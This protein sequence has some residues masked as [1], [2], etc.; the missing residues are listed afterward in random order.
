MNVINKL[1]TVNYTVGRAGRPINLII[2]HTMQGFLTGTD[3][4]FNNPKAQVSAHEGVGLNGEVHLYVDPRNTAWGAGN[5]DYNRRAI[6]LETE[7]NRDPNGVVRTDAQYESLAQRVAL[8]CRQNA[9]P[10]D[11][12]H[13]IKHGEVPGTTHK[14]CPG[15]LDIDRVI[16]RAN[17][18]LTGAAPV[19]VS[20][21]TQPSFIPIPVSRLTVAAGTANVRT[22]PKVGGG[23]VVTSTL[24]KGQT[25]DIDGYLHTG[26]VINSGGYEGDLWVHS[27]MGHW[28]FGP[29]TTFDEA[30]FAP[31][32][33]APVAL[34]FNEQLASVRVTPEIGANLRTAPQ[35]DMAN[36][37]RA[38][39]KETTLGVLGYVTGASVGGNSK[40]W[41]TSEGL[42]ISDAVVAVVTP[43][44]PPATLSVE[45]PAVINPQPLEDP[46][47]EVETEP[48]Q[49]IPP[50][51]PAPRDAWEDLDT[52]YAGLY[53]VKMAEAVKIE[54]LAGKL[55]SVMLRPSQ[56]VRVAGAYKMDGRIMARTVE[57]L[58]TGTAYAIPMVAL[59]LVPSDGPLMA[60]IQPP[61]AP[62]LEG[63]SLTTRERVLA[64]IAAVATL[65]DKLKPWKRK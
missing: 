31:Q 60:D 13:V 63:D 16:R 62:E 23:S 65:L 32:P 4:W 51:V 39:N 44:T 40:W 47:P 54:D 18:I 15:N 12:A 58:R 27:T 41:K 2:L 50:V 35:T 24:K 22:L 61:S 26:T 38:V 36:V 5:L 48:L 29:L 17:E 43:E 9:I 20:T 64:I 34:N 19:I 21:S 49:P 53:E 55:A 7:D 3:S 46:A 56:R 33:A 14:S 10:C 1:I 45:P 59:S 25:F 11:R 42:Y 57:G 30:H 28:V 37:S 6:N 52:S 8:H